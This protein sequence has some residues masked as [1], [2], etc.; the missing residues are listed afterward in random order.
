[1]PSSD[2]AELSALAQSLRR[3][4][5]DRFLTALFAP[6]ERREALFALYVF[7]AEV[8]RIR[9]TVS[10][11]V[12]GQMRI[13]WWRDTIASF[14]QPAAPLPAH[15]TALALAA[16]VR[17]YDL[18]Q[19]PFQMLLEARDRDMDDRPIPDQESL[20][21]YITCT[22]GLLSGLAMA[23]LGGSDAE[24]EAARKVGSAFALC[25]LLRAVPF[26]LHQG[27]C[28]LPSDMMADHGARLDAL[29]GGTMGPAERAVVEELTAAAL[30]ALSESRRG[31]GRVSRQKVAALLPATLAEGSAKRLRKAGYNLFDLRFQQGHRRPLVL[32][33][34]AWRGRY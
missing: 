10:E 30:S 5:G 27:R 32:A 4:D 14:Y 6:P 11:P 3:L 1:M 28:Y 21:A 26:H 23:V 31:V 8:A 15:P 17:E 12:L 13:Q 20:S 24:V 7:N 33:W 34:Q 29:E 25:G 2:S 19:E 9:E 22:G 18:P 16:V